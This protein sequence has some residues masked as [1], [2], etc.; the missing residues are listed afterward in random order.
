MSLHHCVGKEFIIEVPSHRFDV[1]LPED[2]IEELARLYGYDHIPTQSLIATLQ[3]PNEA[4]NAYDWQPLRHFLSDL[5]YH[6]TINYSFIDS[7]LQN[8]FDPTLQ[9]S[10]LKNPLTNEMAVMRT[11]LWPG[12]INSFKYNHSRQQHRIRIFEIGVCFVTKADELV[13]E[14]RVAGLISGNVS[15]EVGFYYTLS[16]FL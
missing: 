6:E 5:G 8:Q 2:I 10:A 1:T 16:R 12:L 4:A 11:N 14:Q 15:P 3:A 7:K 13:H 9:P